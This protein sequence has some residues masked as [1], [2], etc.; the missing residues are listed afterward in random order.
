ML[1][2]AFNSLLSLMYVT[3]IFTF[4]LSAEERERRRRD[5]SENPITSTSKMIDPI[6]LRESTEIIFHLEAAKDK[7]YGMREKTLADLASAAAK[8]QRAI[9]R[10]Q[11]VVKEHINEKQVT[12]RQ[13]RDA[14]KEISL[15]RFV[16]DFRAFEVPGEEEEDRIKLTAGGYETTLD[17]DAGSM[18]YIGAKGIG[19]QSK[20]KTKEEKSNVVSMKSSGASESMKM[21][22]LL[23]NKK[24]GHKMQTS[25]TA[26]L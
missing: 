18:G 16:F 13:L 23:E 25:G 22:M 2:K 14:S 7:I 3:V 15:V 26:Y 8:V 17:F 5:L 12:T 4:S 21:N 9:D 10:L 20:E 6:W 1:L 19:K 11:H 24:A